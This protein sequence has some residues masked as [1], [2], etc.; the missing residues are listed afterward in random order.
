MGAALARA[1][2][3][4]PLGEFATWYSDFQRQDGFVP[5]CVDREGPD[6]LVEHDSHGQMIFAAM[7]AFRFSGDR[8]RLEELWPV[9]RRAASFIETL[10]GEESQASRS[11]SSP[12]QGLLPE[13]ASH[14]G[15]LAQPVHSYW[16]DFW[17]IR[18]L[19]DAA[20]AADELGFS[21]DAERFRRA[22][23]LLGE[24]TQASIRNLIRAKGLTY[25]PGS[26]EWADFDPTATA[27][28]LTLFA[29]T[30][31]LPDRQLLAMFRQFVDDS[32]QRR[33]GD[34]PW[35]NY[36]AY[37]IRIVGALV[38][39]GWRDEAQEFL[40]FY[41]SDRRPRA[42]NQ[43]P[44]ISWR[45]P[46]SPGHLGDIPHT[47]IGAEYMLV[48]A[49]LFAYER[50]RDDSLVIASGIPRDWLS[51]RTLS[52][53]GLSTW[54]GPVDVAMTRRPAGELEVVIGGQLRIPPG[55]IVLRPPLP[56][57]I[58]A[59]DVDGRQFQRFTSEEI[60]LDRTAATVRIA[61]AVEPAHQLATA[62]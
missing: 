9:I 15:Y 31:G 30:A 56:G 22:A 46:R 41:L 43:W 6:W 35:K 1:A 50:D 25:V 19:K 13:S 7:E 4:A 14:E 8:T 40:E 55:G 58:L 12:T 57:P 3:P 42:W 5:C 36:S 2:I 33:R 24:A 20:A 38:R 37:E 62:H 27:N 45:D 21:D 44:E 23:N 52:V 51:R 54:Y 17:G 26:F 48:F 28:A 60:H 18:G 10:C 39:L 49:S 53:R 16:D 11:G 59:V 34:A 61:C 29:D 32:R 47:W